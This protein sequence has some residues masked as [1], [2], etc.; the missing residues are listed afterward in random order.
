MGLAILSE[1]TTLALDLMEVD[2][3]AAFAEDARAIAKELDATELMIRSEDVLGHAAM[4]KEDF[5]TARIH[6]QAALR[7]SETS[8]N[9]IAMALLQNNLG[10]LEQRDP[11]G[12]NKL[13]SEYYRAALG[14][15]REQG[16]RRGEAESLN[17][18]GVLAHSEGQISEA[19]ALYLEASEIASALELPLGLAKTLSNFGEAQMEL[20]NDLGAAKPLGIAEQLLCKLR[21]PYHGYTLELLQTVA[22]RLGWSESQL[23]QFRSEC[24]KVEIKDAISASRQAG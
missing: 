15:Q 22:K 1:R 10:L 20:Q 17:S 11:Q 4:A 8:G 5:A 3:A 9:W 23:E 13:A 14:V 18:L 6:F 19:A 24:G 16:Y 7:L 12:T 2:Q 21:S